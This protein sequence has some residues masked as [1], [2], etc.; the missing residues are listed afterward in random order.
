MSNIHWDLS[1]PAM[2]HALRTTVQG[3]E[4]LEIGGGAGELAE[5]MVSDL[6][7]DHVLVVE[8]ELMF[9]TERARHP[10]ARVNFF[11]G[12]LQEFL[13]APEYKQIHW[14]ALVIS[15][16]VNNAAFDLMVIRAMRLAAQ[17]VVIGKNDGVTACGTDILWNYL[18]TRERIHFVAG[19][20]NDLVVYGPNP[21]PPAQAPVPIEEFGISYL[22]E[23]L[24]QT[25]SRP[26]LPNR[27]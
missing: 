18:V 4:V 10:I 24:C 2:V 8:K 25:T 21:R 3:K 12:Y 16:P 27:N 5:V 11:W 9:R 7:A 1:D 13:Q 14:G 19:P 20:R 6:G 26:L 15:W 17:V 23:P 22:G